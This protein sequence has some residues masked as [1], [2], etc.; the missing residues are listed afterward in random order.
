MQ[1]P[2]PALGLM[3]VMTSVAG[4]QRSMPGRL[5]VS[6]GFPDGVRSYKIVDT[7]PATPATSLII[8]SRGFVSSSAGLEY[9]YRDVQRTRSLTSLMI[10]ENKCKGDHRLTVD[11]TS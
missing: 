1:V 6:L 10:T 2:D 3:T 7:R 5:R 11:E 4:A 9:E 8:I